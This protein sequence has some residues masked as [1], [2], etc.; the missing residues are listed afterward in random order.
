[1]FNT[2]LVPT[3]GSEQAERAVAIASELAARHGTRIVLLHVVSDDK[4]PEELARFAESEHFPKT[5]TVRHVE[6]LEATPHGPV[7]ISGGMREQV[8]HRA[9][10]AE[11]AERLLDSARD[12]AQHRGVERIE[13]ATEWGDP[14]ERILERARREKADGIVMGSRGLSDLKGAFVGSVSHRV[15]HEA[16][17]TCITVT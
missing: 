10:V 8:D 12:V 14:A 2:I 17:C 5:T 16:D 9:V 1:M 3:D 13:V 6:R 11:M 4:V 7:P 15:S